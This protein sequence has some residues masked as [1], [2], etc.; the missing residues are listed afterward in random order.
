MTPRV[1]RDAGVLRVARLDFATKKGGHE[2]DAKLADPIAGADYNW[3][4]VCGPSET[5]VVL[6]MSESEAYDKID[7]LKM[8]MWWVMLMD[9][10]RD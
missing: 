6:L 9:P 8:K 5:V 3:V 7:E 10:K 1:T 2:A 4:H